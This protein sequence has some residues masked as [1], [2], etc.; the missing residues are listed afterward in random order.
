[1][2]YISISLSQE[3]KFTDSATTGTPERKPTLS[4][5]SGLDFDSNKFELE[6]NVSQPVDSLA[7]G[8][9]K[10]TEAR[11]NPP[12]DKTNTDGFLLAQEP[13]AA[14][15]NFLRFFQQFMLNRF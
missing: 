3:V 5:L 2:M 14:R 4:P 11:K 7:E 12:Y 8:A 15:I 6:I 9:H 1:M 10:K 13:A